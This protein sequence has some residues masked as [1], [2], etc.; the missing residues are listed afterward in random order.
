MIIRWSTATGTVHVA[1]FRKS[2]A[3]G[4]CH[5]TVDTFTHG[6]LA[7]GVEAPLVKLAQALT[8]PT[9]RYRLT[10]EHVATA[11]VQ[12]GNAHL[13]DLVVD[14]LWPKQPHTQA[15]AKTQSQP[16]PQPHLE[17]A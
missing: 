8:N 16:Q 7:R 4:S 3:V 5:V 17:A 9:G 11:L 10:Q 6:Q 12:S 14:T 2:Q 1:V 15:Q 13:L